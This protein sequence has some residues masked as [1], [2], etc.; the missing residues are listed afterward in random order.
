MDIIPIPGP[1]PKTCINFYQ[2]ILFPGEFVATM[3]HP[4]II[5]LRF[6]YQELIWF[7][8][9]DSFKA[10]CIVIATYLNRLGFKESI[11]RY[12]KWDPAQWKYSPG[13]LAQLLVI[14]VFIP[15]NKKVAL[16]RI[17]QVYVGM[18]LELLAG[19]PTKP[20]ELSDGFF[21]TMLDRLWEADPRIFL[22]TI[23]L[24][25]RTVF[26]LPPDYVLHSDTTSHVLYGDYESSEYDSDPSL[27]RPTY[28]YSKD[29]R[30][31]LKQWNITSVYLRCLC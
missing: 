11:N 4:H 22:S 23:A 28:G 13:V 18:D 1:H 10:S 27:V 2:H 8:P 7:T 3:Q 26:N 24:T 16:S 19:E 29:K 20:D 6:K 21:V 25:V 15:A 12:V 14:A 17:R 31:D 5:K 9:N 30:D